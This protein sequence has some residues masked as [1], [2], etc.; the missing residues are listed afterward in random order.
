MRVVDFAELLRESINE[1]INECR[2][3]IHES[4]NQ[5]YNNSILIEIRAL[6]W[7]RAQITDL[8]NKERIEDKGQ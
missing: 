3:D 1:K 6:E 7:A 8:V 5:I 2:N 4:H